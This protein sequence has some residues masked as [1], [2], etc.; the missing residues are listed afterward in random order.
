MENFNPSKIANFIPFTKGAIVFGGHFGDEGKGKIVDI[1]ARKFKNEGYKILSIRGQGSGNA[2]HTVIVDGIKYDFHYLTS[3]GLSAD[4]MILGPGMLIDPIKVLEEAEK[5]PKE[6]RKIIMISSRAT[7]CCDLDRAMDSYLESLR[8]NSG[9]PVIGTTKS[10]VGPCEAFRRYRIHLTFADALKFNNSKELMEALINRPLVPEEIKPVITEEYAEKLYNAIN[11]L[12]IVDSDIVIEQ[13]RKEQNW[14]VILE[15]SQAMGL[16]PLKGNSGH[17]VTSTPTTPLG[18]I[19][20]SGLT[21]FDFPDGMY[22]VIK[23]YASKVG[24]GPFITKLKEG[25][26]DIAKFIYDLVGECGVTTGRR[27]DLGWIDVNAIRA[28]VNATGCRHICMNCMDVIGLIP[29]G[30]AKLCYAYKHK[31][32]GEITYNNPYHLAEYEPLYEEIETNWDIVG[33]KSVNDLPLNALKYIKRIEEMINGNVSYTE[34]PPCRISY[35]GNGGSSDAII[36]I[37]EGYLDCIET[38]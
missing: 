26:S 36:K 37:P 32:T 38:L 10:G 35:I 18:A 4:R 29:G 17:F 22:M 11:A 7:I 34:Y 6:K 2:G 14:A 19:D 21:Q 1:L 16:D 8:A 24:G 33:V 31:E 25:E 13:C 5:L 23:A 28:A 9:I 12:N 30:K 20:G 15:V 3:A 27:R